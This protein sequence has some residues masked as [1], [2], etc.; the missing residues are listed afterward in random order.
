MKENLESLVNEMLSNLESF[1]RDQ[2]FQKNVIATI[3]EVCTC[4]TYDNVTNFEWLICHVMVTL[5]RTLNPLMRKVF[6]KQIAQ[7][8]LEISTRLEDVRKRSIT[9]KF[10]FLLQDREF[11]R[12][13]IGQG[14]SDSTSSFDF[15]QSV[16][17]VVTEYC[18]EDVEAAKTQG[19]EFMQAVW[20][21][22]KQE[23]FTP[24]GKIQKTDEENLKVHLCNLALKLAF[25][26]TNNRQKYVTLIHQIKKGTKG[27]S[28]PL[29]ELNQTSDLYSSL[30]PLDHL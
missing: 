1:E 7:I 23:V 3:L 6:E 26:D 24:S 4:N 10:Y 27:S 14:T 18:L 17:Y 16:L 11:I 21:A 8:V 22:L 5:A 9:L 19:L 20:L 13:F 2:Q 25:S 15:L 12:D 28:I 29:L 30:L